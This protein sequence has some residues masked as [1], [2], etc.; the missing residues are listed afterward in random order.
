M[1]AAPAV[2]LVF[3][4]G[5][6]VSALG[7][8]HSLY[9]LYTIQSKNS[10]DRIYEFSA[11]TLLDDR[12]I[13]SYSS[14][15]GV[16]TPKQD[17]MKEMKE[18]EW[19]DGTDKLKYDRELLNW[20]FNKQMK[21]FRHSESDGHTLQW[22]VGCEVEKDSG[23]SLSVL[24]CTSEY[25]YDGQNLIS[26]NWTSRRWSAS[27]S[28]AK[29]LEEEWNAGPVDQ[30]CEDCVHWMKTYLKYSTTDTKLTSLDVHVFAKKSVTDSKKLTLTCLATGFYPK[31]VEIELRKFT[32]SLPE[33]LLTSSGVRPNEDGTYQLRK[34][35]EIQEDETAAEYNCSV[36]HSTLEVPLIKKWE[37]SHSQGALGLAVGGAVASVILTVL[38]GV[39]IF[40][41]KKKQQ[42]TISTASSTSFSMISGPKNLKVVEISP[43]SVKVQWEKAPGKINR[44]ILF[45]S[46]TQ[47]NRP[48]L[49]GE[50]IRK[51][52]VSSGKDSAEIKCLK[53]GRLYD[54]SLVSEKRGVQSQK[55]TVQVT[56]GSKSSGSLGGSME[57]HHEIIV[58]PEETSSDPDRRPND[59]PPGEQLTLLPSTT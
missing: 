33:H 12:Q 25:G 42:A 28:Q 56:P 54:I 52:M 39:V 4:C 23:G 31:D 32:T 48:S 36:T 15:D 47:T 45:V 18:S 59:P 8:E 34:S 7:D 13:D 35:V 53:A 50:S 24:N 51:I 20:V 41:W 26:Y 29:A 6:F 58:M 21:A 10:S 17:W 11:V 40:I 3:L 30:R 55:T 14:T 22:R 44:Y 46:L 49:T 5:V 1:G 2:C 27:V 57:N 16:R 43:T 38:V 19:K 37:R 9:Y